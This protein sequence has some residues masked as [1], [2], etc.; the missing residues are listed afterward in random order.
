MAWVQFFSREE[1]GDDTVENLKKTCEYLVAQ[2]I[3]NQQEADLFVNKLMQ[4]KQQIARDDVKNFP[5]N[6]T[7]I[8]NDNEF[9]QM[10]KEKIADMSYQI[11]I[12][13]IYEKITRLDELV[14]KKE[15][16]GQQRAKEQQ[17]KQ[18]KEALHH[19]EQLEKEQQI[20][21]LEK[22]LDDL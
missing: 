7:I 12:Q 10:Y 11:S 2:N 19:Q 21:S 20:A 4:Q 9:K 8:A 6:V 13:N 18:Q 15:E 3:R 5:Q 1:L 22:M 16:L 14:Q 17:E